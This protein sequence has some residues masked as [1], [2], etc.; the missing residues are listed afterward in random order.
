[1]LGLGGFFVVRYMNAGIKAGVADYY[2]DRGF[3]DY[4][5]IS[6]LGISDDDLSQIKETPG[7]TDAEGVIRAD[8]AM[9]K[10]GQ[11][12][13][14]EII[15]MTERIS[16]PE[17]L[18]GS[19]PASEDEC[20]VGEDFAEES[21][22][23]IGDKVRLTMSGMEALTGASSEDADLVTEDPD[24]EAEE[25][26]DGEKAADETTDGE[27]DGA[28]KD[29]TADGADKDEA[30]DGEAD[31]A[32][33]GSNVLRR[34]EFTITGMMRHPDYLRRKSVNTVVLPAAAYDMDVLNDCFTHVFVKA[35]EPE[36]EDILSDGFFEKTTGTKQALE[37]LT[38]TL[39]VDSATRA[40]NK[41]YAKID[42]EWQKALARLEEGQEEIDSSEATLNSELADARKK[43]K[44]AQK[45]LDSKVSQ[46]NRS[47]KDAEKKIKEGEKT[48]EDG[49]REIRGAKDDLKL[50]DENLALARDYLDQINGEKDG[51]IAEKIRKLT[52]A[53][54]MLDELGKMDPGSEEYRAGA[55]E[56]AAFMIE[57]EED[58]RAVD[59]YA[60]NEE[61]MEDAETLS[62][63]TGKDST[64]TIKKIR[65]F[66]TDGMLTLAHEVDEGGGD[67]E[68]FVKQADEY[69]TNLEEALKTIE[70]YEEYLD[71]YEK[72][73]RSMHKQLSQKEKELAK[74]KKELAAAKKKLAAG[75]KE[76]ASEKK[77]YQAQIKNGW[78]LYYSQKSEYESK[79]EE[80]KELLAEN[81]EE[82]EEKL[83]DARAEVEKI[84]CKWLVFDRRA[85]AGYVD[86]KGTS[87][88]LESAGTAFGLLF[89]LISAIVCFS[90]LTI[91]IEEQK[92]MVGTVKAF[93]FHKSEVLGK[94]M[95]FGVAAAVIGCIAGIL[96]ALGLA[97][98]VLN[99]YNDVAMYQ[100]GDV[101]SVIT[102]GIT[103]IACVLMVIICAL[104]TVIACTDVLKSPAS[105]LMKGSSIKENS[106]RK[107]TS[108]RKG[109]SLYSKLILRNML[110]DKARVLIS[111]AILAFST[112]II[113]TGIST[114][115][116]F[117][118]MPDKQL[119]DVVG[120]DVRVDLG[121]KVTDAQKT[122]LAKTMTDSGADFTAAS[123]ETHLYRWDDKLDA[124]NI[125]T[126]D[127]DK[128]RDYFAVKDPKTGEDLPLPDDGILVQ[129]RMRESY[130]MT[131]GSEI[132]V[133]DSGLD[134]RNAAVKGEFQNYAGRLVVTSPEGYR[135]IFGE[136]PV[137]NCYYVKTNGADRMKLE[138]DLLAISDDVSFEEAEE[139]TTKFESV[140][141]LYNMVVYL[142]TGIGILMSFM[143]LTNM[144]NI[145]LNHKKTELTVMRINGFS[146]KQTKGYLARETV[147]TT[148]AGTILG[149][150][151]GAIAAPPIIMMQEP[152]DIQFVRTFHPAAWIIAVLLEV[153]FAV[154]IYSLVFRKVKDLNFRDVA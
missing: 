50:M 37:E 101:S 13:N 42:R 83:A 11:N 138:S 52:E 56:L 6:S 16:V 135:T 107:K 129:K 105:V 145:F 122:E 31:T 23:K 5:L 92:K 72:E 99:I 57:N 26:A 14:V 149:V 85:N 22:L 12:R 109:G 110:D 102:P 41:A 29:E 28:N 53:R 95:V 103:V 154:I 33:D 43:L 47:L 51:S 15:S 84:E 114:K 106:G 17:V 4:E 30:A 88:A 74:G 35:E 91:I 58:I 115:L 116:A 44:D 19:A 60:R 69:T 9:Q 45:E 141:F 133:L 137:Y 153:V 20:M 36:G 34:K 151:A 27:A 1:M 62:A 143:I 87:A 111:I 100:F 142:T 120:Y 78:S 117:D 123:Y 55:K 71:K 144:A 93:G 132:P 134:V 54:T 25:A 113:G 89:L 150:L 64:G 131:E 139:F 98:I 146:I 8:G 94:Y 38:E 96:L 73:N 2:A 147:V 112:L 152:L 81:R 46:G 18:E 86:I 119:S 77:K 90:T 128:I 24:E 124:L 104:A 118:K 148:A 7:I 70:E 108:S 68:A 65:D 67:A 59:E 39:A 66:D 10:G 82:A 130:D 32:D 61:T 121:D 3:K 79:L 127:P 49:E 97:V 136:A 75:K 48:I 126:G 63:L 21:G 140:S 125:L 40:K 80:A 76:L